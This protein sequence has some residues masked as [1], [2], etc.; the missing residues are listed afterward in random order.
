MTRA[1]GRG[2][3]RFLRKHTAP[4]WPL[5]MG[6]GVVAA[7]AS[8]GL[9]LVGASAELAMALCVGL[10][11]TPAVAEVVR[12]KMLGALGLRQAWGRAG[13]VDVGADGVALGG[14]K[15]RFV[16]YAEL[17]DVRAQGEDL[18]RLTLEGGEEL[19]VGCERSDELETAIVTAWAD[20]Q[21]AEPT[22]LAL[23]ERAEARGAARE[24]SY[25]DEPVTEAELLAIAR[26]PKAPAAARRRAF[27]A[28]EGAGPRVQRKL[29]IA[30]EEIAEPVL[31]RELTTKGATR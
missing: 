6:G 30:L 13:F 23:V 11:L 12:T 24:G 19:L 21:W 17:A 31:R 10:S 3:R 16:S 18:V 25:R 1:D 7:V 4:L 20:Y 28:L 27:E 9:P 22:N 8:L 2:G 5:L 15:A 26:D 14:W 29:R